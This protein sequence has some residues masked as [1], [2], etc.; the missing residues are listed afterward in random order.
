M[1]TAG[2]LRRLGPYVLLRVSGAGGMA[3]VEVALRQTPRGPE[4]CVLKR[5]HADFRSPEQEARFRREAAI[6]ARL[7]HDAIARTLGIEEIDDEPVLLQ[8][9]VMG[10]DLRRLAGRM[11][12]VGERLPIPLAAYVVSEVA[13]ALDHAHGLGNLGIVHRDVTP[14]NIML[15]FSGVVKLVDFG[16]ARS[17]ADQTLT[18]AGLVIG[19]P[20]Y[21]APEVW[22]GERA[23]RRSDIYS[24]GV[25]LWQLLTGRPVDALDVASPA[26]DLPD[27][28]ARLSVAALAA[29]PAERPQ[30]A[31]AFRDA[32]GPFVPMDDQ[33]RLALAELL[34]RHFD[35]ARENQMLADDVARARRVLVETEG[36]GTTPANAPPQRR[37]RAWTAPNRG[38]T[39]ALAVPALVLLGLVLAGLVFA[40]VVGLVRVAKAR[41][42]SQAGVT[43][44]APRPPL[45]NPAAS[46]EKAPASRESERAWP[47]PD[48]TA[49]RVPGPKP[50]RRRRS[51]APSASDS[52]A[53][54]DALV[55]RAEVSFD[56]GDL[57]GA[58]AAARHALEAG[59]GAPAQLV[60]GTVMMNRRRYDEAER[61]FA[62]ATRLAPGDQT[63]ARLLAMIR[64]I[65]KME[66]GGR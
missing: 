35:V 21:T 30:T 15:G 32:L 47:I 10:V 22:E 44:A 46:V 5:M 51:A 33:A 58:L 38:V 14:E 53:L 56:R 34:A 62:E 2:E 54:A 57:D 11:T 61:A 17:N 42:R 41:H 60:I 9:L 28:L 24:L 55:Q 27:P 37:P 50:P 13:R 31:G 25:V 39:R 18:E 20:V 1:E 26:A 3:R 48:Q 65:R 23:D 4:L 19:R 12:A 6:A 63:A 40:G 16:I 8:E 36:R 64:D 52:P 59:A 43:S 45:A 66:G 29:N 49:A 7:C